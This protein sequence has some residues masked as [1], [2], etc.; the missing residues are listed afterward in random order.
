MG[1]IIKRPKAPPAPAP[2]QYVPAPAPAPVA[3][4]PPPPPAPV[5]AEPTPE[6]T[7]SEVRKDNLLRRNRGRFGTVRT[8]F[9]GVLGLSGSNAS[10]KE[11]LGE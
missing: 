11:L 2:V 1:S 4:P 6:E 9:R 10:G 7:A 8:G 3:S 5:E